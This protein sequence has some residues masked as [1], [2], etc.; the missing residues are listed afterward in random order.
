MI[1]HILQWVEV[2]DLRGNALLDHCTQSQ[3]TEE[4][5]Y[6]ADTFKVLV[7]DGK[8]RVKREITETLG[9]PRYSSVKVSTSIEVTCDQSRDTIQK[10]ALEVFAEAQILNDEA[11]ELAWSKLQE[12]IKST[13][14]EG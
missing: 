10:A 8:A 3:L 4:Q 14:W 12:H 11:V 1:V 9:G 6:M 7:G 2:F 13:D 5:L